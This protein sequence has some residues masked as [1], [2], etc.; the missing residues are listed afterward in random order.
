MNSLM[1]KK[2]IQKD[3][4][5]SR[6]NVYG[7]LTIGYI[8]L[9]SYL[10]GGF[11][12]VYLGA[13]ALDIAV[14]MLMFF[15]VF[16]I[17]IFERKDQTLPFIMSLP[18]SNLEYT[19]AKTLSGVGSYFLAWL[20]LY[21]SAIAVLLLRIDLNGSVLIPYFTMLYSGVLMFYCIGFAV[22]MVSESEPAANIVLAIGNV[23]IQVSIGLGMTFEGYRES[24]RSPTILWNFPVLTTLSI[25]LVVIVLCIAAMFFLQLRKKDLL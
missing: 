11:Y 3:W 21:V 14:V 8:G 22:A 19:M 6:F 1:I 4:H 13:V 5:M 7:C 9:I 17:V 12:G 2:L 15:H 16:A 23:V 10:L 24:V 25:E 18:V 20:L